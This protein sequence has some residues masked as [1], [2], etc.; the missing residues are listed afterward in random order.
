MKYT[1]HDN[2][3]TADFN[4][5]DELKVD[6]IE[7]LLSL[8][9]TD[10]VFEMI[11]IVI[12]KNDGLELF[13]KLLESDIN[14]F[15]FTLSNDEEIRN[16]SNEEIVLVTV[17]TDGHIWIEKIYPSIDLEAEF[18]YIDAGIK[19]IWLQKVNNGYN[20]ILIFDMK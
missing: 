2:V 9:K 11:N 6:I 1:R 4:C 18:F 3:Q 20:D 19:S 14:G 12:N 7:N 17:S 16:L 10:N 8:P 5:L 13:N 15:N